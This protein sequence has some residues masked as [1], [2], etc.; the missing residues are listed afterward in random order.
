MAENAIELGTALEWAKAW[1]NLEDKSSYVNELKGWWAPGSD[2]SQ[3]TQEGAVDSR[4][5][6]GL[7]GTEIKLMLVGVNADGQDMINAEEGWFIYDATK[8]CPPM[9][10]SESPLFNV[11]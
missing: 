10:D 4:M 6:I 3:V 11:G 5:Y 7:K 1:R 9:C 8:P 2:L